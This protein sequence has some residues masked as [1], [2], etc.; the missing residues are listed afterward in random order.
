MDKTRLGKS[1]AGQ[2]L[3]LRKDGCRVAASGEIKLTGG[4]ELGTMYAVLERLVKAESFPFL[5]CSNEFLPN[6]T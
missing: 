1:T 2:C 6:L 4:P 5:G 3:P